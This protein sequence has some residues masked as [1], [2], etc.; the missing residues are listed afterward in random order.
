MEKGKYIRVKRNKYKRKIEPDRN[1]VLQAKTVIGQNSYYYTKYLLKCTY[2]NYI[3]NYVIRTHVG[4]AKKF[5]VWKVPEFRSPECSTPVLESSPYFRNFRVLID[6]GYGSWTVLA[7][8][9]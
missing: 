7:S 2:V 6:P 8:I 3:V 1:K 5:G 4:E 9:Y